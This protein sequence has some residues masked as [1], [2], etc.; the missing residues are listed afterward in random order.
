MVRCLIM[1]RFNKRKQFAKFSKVG[2][3]IMKELSD[4]P[5]KELMCLVKVTDQY[6]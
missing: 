4:G 2:L 3:M 1:F 5:L 6:Q